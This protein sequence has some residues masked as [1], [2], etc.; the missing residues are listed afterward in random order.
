MRWK[1]YVFKRQK[2]KSG[3]LSIGADGDKTANCEEQKKKK[4][5][6]YKTNEAF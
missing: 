3:Y 1:C 4:K 2:R 5:E 6:I